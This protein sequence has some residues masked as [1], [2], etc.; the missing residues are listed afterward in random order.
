MHGLAKQT[1]GSSAAD[2]SY[3]ALHTSLVN[4]LIDVVRG[5]ARLQLA[6]RHIQNLTSETANSPHPLLLLFIQDLDAALAKQALLGDRNAILR[7]VGIGNGGWDGAPRRQRVDR[8]Q[9]TG[10]LEGGKRVEVASSWI[11]FRNYFRR[12]EVGERITLFVDSFVLTLLWSAYRS[13]SR[14]EHDMPLIIQECLPNS[15]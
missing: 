3:L 1:S 14:R 5:H 9:G 11:R 12:E 4:D 13:P 2:R 8:A 7:V 6:G 10:E 15:A